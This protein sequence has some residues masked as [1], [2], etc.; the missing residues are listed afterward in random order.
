MSGGV[1]IQ[2][3]S[4]NNHIHHNTIT[5]SGVADDCLN[6]ADCDGIDLEV[7]A[8]DNSVHDNIVTGGTQNGIQSDGD[9]NDIQ[10]NFVCDNGD[11]DIE[12]LATADLNRVTNNI[13][14]VIVDGGTNTV[15]MNNSPCPT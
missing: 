3:R 6:G 7:T 13:A 11:N 12:I 15:E 14:D 9:R 5:D 10:M 4:D 2:V 1:G 8:D